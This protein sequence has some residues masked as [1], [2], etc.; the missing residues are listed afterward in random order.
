MRTTFEIQADIAKIGE[1]VC[2]AML[3]EERWRREDNYSRADEAHKAIRYANDQIERLK[4]ERRLSS[5]AG[6]HGAAEAP[7]RSVADVSWFEHAKRLS[8]MMA[9]M[10]TREQNYKYSIARMITAYTG[11]SVGPE[12]IL[13][14]DGAVCV[15]RE[16]DDT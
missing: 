14:R 4:E 3:D 16:Q 9:D 6:L 11:D 13:L 8:D 12:D 2:W 7:M 5:A 15:R 10:A 1:F